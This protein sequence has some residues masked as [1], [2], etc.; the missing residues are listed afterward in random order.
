LIEVKAVH[1]DHLRTIPPNMREQFMKLA[2]YDVLNSIY[3]IRHRFDNMN[4]PYGQ[5][6]LFID[7]VDNAA[8]EREA[9]LSTF[10]ENMLRASDA[11]RI[12]IS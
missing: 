9:L 8:S 11:K 2:L 6:Q 7:L 10:Q 12:W 4:T 5:I 1:P 3:P